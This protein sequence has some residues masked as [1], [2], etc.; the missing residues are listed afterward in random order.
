MSMGSSMSSSDVRAR[1]D[2]DSLLQVPVDAAR[3]KLDG[4]PSVETVPGGD[5][6][7]RPSTKRRMYLRMG[8]DV[9]DLDASD[10][11]GPLCDTIVAEGPAVGGSVVSEHDNS[12]F[13]EKQARPLERPNSRWLASRLPIGPAG[14]NVVKRGFDVVASSILMVILAPL[15]A[16]VGLWIK[17]D[18]K[19]PVLFVQERVGQAGHVFPMFKFRTMRNGADAEKG[20][21]AHLNRS[22]DPR[23]FKIPD[24]PRVTKSGVLLRRWSVDEIPQLLNVLRGEMSLVG[25]RPFFESDL[26]DYDVH[27]FARLAVKPGLTGL[28]QVRGRSSILDFEE[29]VELDR[30]YIDNW[31]L[32]L[33]LSILLST[34]PAVV[35]R[36]GAY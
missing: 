20:D 9:S 4:V 1:D 31:S 28:W 18:S 33:D 22:G 26:A 3:L 10:S 23:L 8:S 7:L 35:R 12:T 5:G 30:Q 29:V 24:D 32:G 19:G 11:P 34:I 17:L 25:P 2:L 15:F 14:H 21:F 13:T 6:S 16:L 36:T 27:H